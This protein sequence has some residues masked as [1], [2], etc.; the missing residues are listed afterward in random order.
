MNNAN[1]IR[2]K[3]DIPFSN[4]L[5]DWIIQRAS[6]IKYHPSEYAPSTLEELQAATRGSM[7]IPI[8]DAFNDDNIFGSAEVNMAFRAW[9]DSIHLAHNLEMDLLG[10]TQAA[11]IQ[12]SELPSDWWFERYLLMTEIT[13]QV[14]YYEVHKQFVNEQRE[15]TIKV[16]TTGR[17]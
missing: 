12:A 8:L 1:F 15:Y 6:S 5:N 7:P 4:R 3:K 17:I 2:Y 11:F 13:G 9:H 10:E 16:L 14:C